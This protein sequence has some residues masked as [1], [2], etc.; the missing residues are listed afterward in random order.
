MPKHVTSNIAAI[1]AKV[2]RDCKGEDNL[3][4]AVYWLGESLAT[5]RKLLFRVVT[6]GLCQPGSS[7]GRI[8]SIPVFLLI[9]PRAV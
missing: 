3:V 8:I 5:A 4:V 2:Q 6:K 9:S 7:L 1:K